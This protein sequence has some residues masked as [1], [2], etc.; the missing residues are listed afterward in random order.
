MV[1]V[2]VVVVV[3]FASGRSLLVSY[4]LQ[5]RLAASPRLLSDPCPTN[6]HGAL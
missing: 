5:L 4:E 1:V 2:V 6:E 3:V